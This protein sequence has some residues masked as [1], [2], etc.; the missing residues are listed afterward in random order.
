MQITDFCVRPA[1]LPVKFLFWLGS[2]DFP[3]LFA[4]LEKQGVSKLTI[5]NTFDGIKDEIDQS[6]GYCFDFNGSP[7]VWTKRPYT[8]KNMGTI[9]HE[10]MHAIFANG[11]YIGIQDEEWDCYMMSYLLD[12]L[13]AESLRRRKDG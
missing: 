2:S 6:D 4:F 13:R 7:L 10:I 11:R 5:H 1:G 3:A 12:K 9:C 8:H